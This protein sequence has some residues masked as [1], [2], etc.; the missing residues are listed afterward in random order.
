MS[1]I[2]MLDAGRNAMRNYLQ[3]RA[4]AFRHGK[5]VQNLIR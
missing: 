5:L 4:E 2:L 1:M 3:M